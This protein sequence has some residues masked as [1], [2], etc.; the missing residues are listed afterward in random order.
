MYCCINVLLYKYTYILLK[1]AIGHF[2][3]KKIFFFF[4]NFFIVDTGLLEVDP[5]FQ[6]HWTFLQLIMIFLYT[7]VHCFSY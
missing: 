7:L 4:F 2:C 6:D 1:G 5:K 3:W